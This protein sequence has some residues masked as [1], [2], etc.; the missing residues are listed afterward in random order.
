MKLLCINKD[1]KTALKEGLRDGVPI[2]L[3]YL[4]VSFSLGIAAKSAGLTAVQSFFASI[5]CSASAGEYAGFT[6]IAANASYIEMAII[7]FIVNARYMLMGCAMSQ[8]LSPQT[9]LRHRLL[10]SFGITDEIF[11][12]AI[13]RPGRLNP[14]YNY[15]AMLI[16]IP[17]WATGTAI[18]T[19]A[20][21]LLPLRLISAFSVALYGM[22]LAV[23]VPPARKDKI[24][25]GIIMF[26]FAASFSAEYIPIFAQVSTGLRTIIL[27]L[28][29]SAV[30]AIIFPRKQTNDSEEEAE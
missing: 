28:V 2:G 25:A 26:C 6:L 22:F 15:G 30:A 29:I 21:N 16:A 11:A 4:A 10:M 23:I 18:G 3:G 1:N 19:I 27:T 5:L 8:R 9:K 24:I 7:T 20:G 17:L 13:A 14:Y 12:V